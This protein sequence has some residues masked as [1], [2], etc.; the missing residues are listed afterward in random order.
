LDP[1]FVG[2]KLAEENGFLSTI[3]IRSTNVVGFYGMLK[4]LAQCERVISS[5]KFTVISRQVPP[6]SLLGASVG[7][8]KTV[9]VNESEMIRT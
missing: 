6:E 1:R 3:K 5:E 9:L 4:N 7:I 2:S 8:F